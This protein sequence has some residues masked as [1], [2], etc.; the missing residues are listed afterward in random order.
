MNVEVVVNGDRL[1][2]P[3]GATVADVVA[4]VAPGTGG[5]GTAVAVGDEVV[6]AGRWATT[7]LA[8]GDRV[9]VLHAVA[10]G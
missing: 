8:D 1:Q 10:G 9:E 5:R 7:A 4:R 6:P 3:E 2:L